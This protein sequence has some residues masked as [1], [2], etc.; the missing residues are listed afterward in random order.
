MAGQRLAIRFGEKI[1][2]IDEYGYP[3]H[4][5]AFNTVQSKK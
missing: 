3:I 4:Y 1:A 2:G 5:C